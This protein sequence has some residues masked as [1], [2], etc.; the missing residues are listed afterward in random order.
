MNGRMKISER[1]EGGVVVL[2]VEGRLDHEAAEEFRLAAMRRIG[3]GARALLVD[4]GGTT[5]LASMGI[6]ALILPSQEIAQ[7]GGKLAVTGLSAEL[8]KLFQT[9]GLYQ[10]FTVYPSVAEGIRAMGGALE[11]GLP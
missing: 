8:E 7:H 11:E 10:L 9:A 5:F 2:A 1:E 6:R 3:E 4:F